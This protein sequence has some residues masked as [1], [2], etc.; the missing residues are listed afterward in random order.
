M[1]W[2]APPECPQQAEVEQRIE[3]LLRQPLDAQRMASLE[4]SAE[5]R[6]DAQRGYVA[7]LRVAT[8]TGTQQRELSHQDCA[9]LAEA[10]AFVFAIAIDPE[11]VAAEEDTQPADAQAAPAPS[12]VAAAPSS[13]PAPSAP[14][15]PSSL[16]IGS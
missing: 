2:H 12:T 15:E 14:P 10:S 16:L 7:E 3:R 5:V 8:A 1:F 11:L 4:L 6:G 13:T 9:E